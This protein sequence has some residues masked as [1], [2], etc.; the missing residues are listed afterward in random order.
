MNAVVQSPDII[1]CCR[2]NSVLVLAIAYSQVIPV[3]ILMAI[4]SGT[5]VTVALES[6]VPAYKHQQQ[7]AVSVYRYEGYYLIKYPRYKNFTQC[8][9]IRCHVPLIQFVETDNAEEDMRFVLTCAE[10]KS[11]GVYLTLSSH[12]ESATDTAEGTT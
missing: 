6:T 2:A 3:Q 12:N 10:P 7:F 1:H 11:V 4:F 9:A 8:W 5:L